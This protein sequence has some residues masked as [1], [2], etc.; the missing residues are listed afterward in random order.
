[1]PTV[2]EVANHVASIVGM[3]N[4]LLLVGE[5]VARRWQE[6][7]NSTTLRAL[8]KQGELVIPTPVEDG[9]VAATQGS[10]TITGTG[11]AFTSDLVGRHIRIKQAWYLIAQVVSTTSLALQTEYSETT[12]TGAGYHIVKRFH[13]LAPDVRKIGSFVHMRLRRPLQMVSQI[14]MDLG[15]PSRFE[16]ADS[17]FYVSEVGPTAQGVRQVEIY[18]YSNQQEIVHYMYWAAPPKLGFTD[19]IPG[20]I[21]TEALREG[22]LIDVYRHLANRMA[23]KGDINAAGYYRN[24]SRAQE[25]AWMRVHKKRLFQQDDGIDDLEFIL[26]RQPA[27]PSLNRERAIENAFD[28]VWNR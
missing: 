25:T 5:F 19:I 11:T 17:P 21:D 18:P 12:I 10:T 28:Y 3:D 2:E 22:V 13:E 26:H 24:E 7:A 23:Q 20:D 14:G 6:V 4:D 9:T 15:R 16:L 27:H 1:M 8:R